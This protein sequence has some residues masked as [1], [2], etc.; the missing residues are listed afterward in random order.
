MNRLLVGM[1]I[2]LIGASLVVDL[3]FDIDLPVV[4]LAV[5]A[6]LVAWGA[7]M[8]VHAF[9]GRDRFAVAREPS[10]AD[11]ELTPTGDLAHD[12]RF[13]VAFGRGL[14]I[15]PSA[16]RPRESETSRP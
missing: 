1:V 14:A 5:A 9:A 11:R 7:R 4:R 10:L 2:L 6:L 12:V 3:L 16:A 8:V 13:D 15:R